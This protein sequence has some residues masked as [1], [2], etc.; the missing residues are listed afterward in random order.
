[1]A[2]FGKKP[3]HPFYDKNGNPIKYPFKPSDHNP[4]NHDH[5]VHIVMSKAQ[6]TGETKPPYEY[7]SEVIP[8]VQSN[9]KVTDKDVVLTPAPAYKTPGG[10]E[11]SDDKGGLWGWQLKGQLYLSYASSANITAAADLLVDLTRT[12]R[13][14]GKWNDYKSK[15]NSLIRT[16]TTAPKKGEQAVY[17]KWALPDADAS[18][19]PGLLSATADNPAAVL[20]CGRFWDAFPL[21]YHHGYGIRQNAAV[22][23]AWAKA[24]ADQAWIVDF[25][26]GALV[27]YVGEP[28][29][30]DIIKGSTANSSGHWHERY[31]THYGEPIEHGITANML[32][33]AKAVPFM[34]WLDDKNW[35]PSETLAPKPKAVKGV[36]ASFASIP[37]DGSLPKVSDFQP[38]GMLKEALTYSEDDAKL[39]MGLGKATF[40]TAKQPKAEF[41]VKNLSQESL[42]VIF[43][44]LVPLSELETTQ[45]P[46]EQPVIA[47]VAL[48]ELEEALQK[49]KEP[50]VQ[51]DPALD[52]LLA[53]KPAETVQGPSTFKGVFVAKPDPLLDKLLAASGPGSTAFKSSTGKITVKDAEGNV[54]FKSQGSVKFQGLQGQGYVA[55]SGLDAWEFEAVD[56]LLDES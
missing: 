39:V 48:S 16:W 32:Q 40:T 29:S 22:L 18:T 24:T 34:V 15:V 9:I 5:H 42:D 38:L 44:G 53:P 3:M 28:W 35:W 11:P 27:L 21:G 23:P 50:Q 14:Q 36:S 55:D 45:Q 33:P 46:K 1:M 7:P 47:T 56:K 43:G 49:P 41:E 8:L 12:Y 10:Y 6:G 20:Q 2:D 26:L 37:A 4:G 51:T 30:N 31:K 17:K 25:D 13:N 19:W 54:T 52:S